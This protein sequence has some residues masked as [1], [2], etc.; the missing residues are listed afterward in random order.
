MSINLSP[1]EK[2]AVIDIFHGANGSPTGSINSELSKIKASKEVKLCAN[3]AYFYEEKCLRN[4]QATFDP[5][6]GRV[7][8]NL[9][10]EPFCIKERES[11]SIFI[12][13][14]HPSH[15]GPKGKFWKPDSG[16]RRLIHEALQK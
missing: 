14:E 12:F 3:C 8:L 16:F 9:S 6:N 2:D 11:H 10:D 5:V 7:K 13:F 1:K 4:I 15:C